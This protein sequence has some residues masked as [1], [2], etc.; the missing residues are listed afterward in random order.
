MGFHQID[1]IKRNLS[2]LYKDTIAIDSL[3]PDAV[4]DPGDFATI[5]KTPR[6]ATPVSRPNSFGDV[7]HCDII[8]GPEVVLANVHYGLLFTDCFSRMTYIFPLQNLNADIIKQ[9]DHFF[10]VRIYTSSINLRF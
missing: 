5:K 8:F 2:A 9:L 6:N 3:P 4:L 1:T 10:A 7:I